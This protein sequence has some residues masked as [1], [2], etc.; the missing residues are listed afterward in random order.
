MPVY[1]KPEI[2]ITQ[3]HR[4]FILYCYFAFRL[5]LKENDECFLLVAFELPTIPRSRNVLSQNKLKRSN[6][7]LCSIKG[8]H[9]EKETKYFIHIEFLLCGLFNLFPMLSKNDFPSYTTEG[10]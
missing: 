5:C 10:N 9:A 3:F 2:V 8:M 6:P 4:N 1:D 7:H